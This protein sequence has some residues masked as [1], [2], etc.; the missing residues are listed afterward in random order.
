MVLPSKNSSGQLLSGKNVCDHQDSST[1]I[2]S[3]GTGIDINAGVE[4][5]FQSFYSLIIDCDGASNIRKDIGMSFLSILL[6]VL[7]VGVIRVVMG[8]FGPC[9]WFFFGFFSRPSVPM[10]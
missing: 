1:T 4:W 5:N 9:E 8:I 3:P 6:L 2:Q 10:V 7:V